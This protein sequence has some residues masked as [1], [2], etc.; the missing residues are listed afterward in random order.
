M[1]SVLTRNEIRSFVTVFAMLTLGNL[2]CSQNRTFLTQEEK[3]WN[4]YEIGQKLIFG[5]LDG[6]RDTMEITKSSDMQF[7][8]GIGSLQNERLNV[9]ARIRDLTISRKPIEV[10]LLYMFARSKENPSRIK[11]ELPLAGG[12]FWGKGYSFNE[13]G[14]YDE[15][16]LHTPYG[17]FEDVIKIYDNSNQDLRDKD[18]SVI[19]WSKSFGYVRCEKKDGTIWDLLDIHK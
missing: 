15:I 8:D 14:N 5:T 2:S 12:K 17:Q 11:F 7:A 1:N 9:L 4:P 3:A 13:L 19:F 18:I 16:S 10:T 6:R